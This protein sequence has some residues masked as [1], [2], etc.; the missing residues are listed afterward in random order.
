MIFIKL[1][2]DSCQ[3]V[4]RGANRSAIKNPYKVLIYKDLLNLLVDPQEPLFYVTPDFT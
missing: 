4:V 3:L 1:T 2:N